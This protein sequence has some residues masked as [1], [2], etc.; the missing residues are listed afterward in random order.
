MEKLLLGI[1]ALKLLE[2]EGFSVLQSGLARDENEA[3]SISSQIGFPVALKVSSP[4]VIHKTEIDGVRFPVSSDKEVIEGFRELMQGFRSANP[5]KDV[6]GIMIQRIGRGFELIVGVHKD[7][8]FGPVIMFGFGGIF[9]EAI[10]DVSFRVIPIDKKDAREMIEELSAYRILT[11]PRQKEID[12]ALIEDFL[13][14]ISGFVIKHKEIEGMDLN[15]VF[16]SSAGM[17][18]CDARIRCEV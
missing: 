6:E 7:N 18:I 9:V 1:D 15:P 14:K 13:V 16:I 5:E 3:V 10:K 12:L 2:K 17:S 8:Q 11:S 4:S